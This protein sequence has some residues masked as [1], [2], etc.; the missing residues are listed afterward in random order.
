MTRLTLN[1]TDNP[2]GFVEIKDLSNKKGS[3]CIKCLVKST[4]RKSFIDKS[5]C[6]KYAE[7]IQNIMTDEGI[8]YNENKE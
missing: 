1:T 2:P 3:P 6:E 7:F 5:A 4:C 8:P